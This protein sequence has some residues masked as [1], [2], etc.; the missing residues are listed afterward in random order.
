MCNASFVKFKVIFLE[1]S[2]IVF[3]IFISPKIL[4]EHPTN[5]SLDYLN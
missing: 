2:N 3:N 5:V 1:D 4:Q